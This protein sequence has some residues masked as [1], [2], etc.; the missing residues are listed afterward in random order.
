[1][2]IVLFLEILAACSIVTALLTQA[3]KKLVQDFSTNILALATGM[4]VG[5]SVTAIVYQLVGIVFC[6]N[7][8][9]CMFLM[10]VASA[11]GAMLGYDKVTQAITQITSK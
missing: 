5:V 2:T 10:G 1:M 6:T 3:E 8:V 7:N 9:I 4:V 11:L